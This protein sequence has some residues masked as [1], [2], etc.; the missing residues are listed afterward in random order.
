MKWGCG[1]DDALG[2]VEMD[3]GVKGSAAVWEDGSPMDGDGKMI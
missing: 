2:S 1:G 3:C